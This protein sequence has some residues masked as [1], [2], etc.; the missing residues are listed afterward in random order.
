MKGIVQLQ[1]QYKCDLAVLA[2]WHWE[3]TLGLHQDNGVGQDRITGVILCVLYELL[4][5]C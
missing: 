4:K 5:E 2:A 3:K 1:S